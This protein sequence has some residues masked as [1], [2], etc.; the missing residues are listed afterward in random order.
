M[1]ID[2]YSGLET[3]IRDIYQ[4]FIAGG[5]EDYTRKLKQKV[6]AMGLQDRI[7]FAGY[8]PAALMPDLY[9]E[10]FALIFPSLYEGFGIPLLEAM[11]SGCPVIVSNTA[12]MPEVCGDAALYIN[13]LDLDS[14]LTAIETLVRKPLVRQQLIEKGISRAG[15]FSWKQM[16]RA[17]DTMIDTSFTENKI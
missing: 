2:V 17:F 7:I 6:A 16:A 9:R 11:A 8:V 10:A 1:L 14:L 13:P 3:G 15:L 12:S 4:L 5:K